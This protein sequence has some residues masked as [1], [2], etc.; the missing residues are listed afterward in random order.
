MSQL[1]GY[2][3]RHSPPLK[4]HAFDR[5]QIPFATGNNNSAKNLQMKIATFDEG[6]ER[7]TGHACFVLLVNCVKDLHRIKP[8]EKACNPS[9]RTLMPNVDSFSDTLV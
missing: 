1:A 3:G 2:F 4:R 6:L 8:L 7:A 5:F 9:H